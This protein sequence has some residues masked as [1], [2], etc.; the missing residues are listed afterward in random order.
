MGTYT[1]VFN[2]YNSLVSIYQ[3][4]KGLEAQYPSFTSS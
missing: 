3:A 4:L 1:N 2:Y